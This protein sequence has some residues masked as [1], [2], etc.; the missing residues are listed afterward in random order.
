MRAAGPSRRVSAVVARSGGLSAR[1]ALL[2][3]LACLTTLLLAVGFSGPEMTQEEAA[4][5]TQPDATSGETRAAKRPNIVFV[6]TDDLDY[7]SAQKMPQ[8]GSLLREGGTSFE[9]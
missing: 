9:E 7:A 4:Y 2:K 6:L 1:R 8:I 3:L 5:T